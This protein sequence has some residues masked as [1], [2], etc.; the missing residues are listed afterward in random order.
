MQKD[1]WIVLRHIYITKE[2]HILQIQF[3]MSIQITVF[4]ESHFELK[5][6]D[7]EVK[8]KIDGYIQDLKL[9]NIDYFTYYTLCKWLLEDAIQ[10][11]SVIN[12]DNNT[13]YESPMMVRREYTR[14]SRLLWEFILSGSLYVDFFDNHSIAR[15]DNDTTFG[16]I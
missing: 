14:V 2:L 15:Y 3:I 12:Y 1:N 10:N 9:K 4:G 16:I 6:S 11:N 7:E 13:Y 5:Y 8:Q